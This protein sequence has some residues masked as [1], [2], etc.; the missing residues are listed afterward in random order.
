MGPFSFLKHL[1]KFL[2]LYFQ[3]WACVD[4]LCCLISC[5]L[6]ISLSSVADSVYFEAF[7]NSCNYFKRNLSNRGR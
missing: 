4:Y 6:I 2:G 5:L 1:D 7:D 3:T